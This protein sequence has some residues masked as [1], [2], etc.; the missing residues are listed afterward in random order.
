MVQLGLKKRAEDEK[1]R[2]SRVLPEVV[3]HADMVDARRIEK[4]ATTTIPIM[5]VVMAQCWSRAQD[6]EE[7]EVVVV[8]VETRMKRE[9]IS[10]RSWRTAIRDRTLNRWRGLRSDN[11]WGQ[12][13]GRKRGKKKKKEK[14]EGTTYGVSI[15]FPGWE[16]GHEAQ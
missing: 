14:R 4:M 6:K 16:D 3:R 7:E 5:N 11:V 1:K 15:G 13:R 10:H 12:A 8:V 9:G 2:R